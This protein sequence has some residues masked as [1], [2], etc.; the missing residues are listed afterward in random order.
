MLGTG[1]PQERC[2]LVARARQ[3]QMSWCD[4]AHSIKRP[5]FNQASWHRQIRPSNWPS[6]RAYIAVCGAPGAEERAM[7][8]SGNEGNSMS[9]RTSSELHV[10]EIDTDA[11]V[12]TKL[13]KQPAGAKWPVGRWGA[14]LTALPS[15]CVLWGGWSRAGDVDKAWKLWLREA[16]PEWCE[17]SM[18][19]VNV[20]PQVA[21]H[22]ASALPDG[23]MAVVGGLGDG[24]S[25]SGVWLFDALSDR[26]DQAGEGG[27]TCAGH[28]AGVDPHSQRL[29]LWGGVERNRNRVLPSDHFLDGLR[30]FDIRQQ[31]WVDTVSSPTW[32][33]E[34]VSSPPRPRRNAAFGNL[35]SHL[36]MT[37]GYSDELHATLEDTWILNLHS[38]RWNR[39][40]VSGAPNLEGHRAVISGLD[41][42]TFGGRDTT[43]VRAG[44]SMS[45]SRLRLGSGGAGETGLDLGQEQDEGSEESEEESIEEQSEEEQSEEEQSE[46]EVADENPDAAGQF[47][48]VR[49]RDNEGAVRVV[50]MPADLLHR[51]ILRQQVAEA[52]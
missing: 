31:R 49:V 7:L 39:L 30:I 6:H 23:R 35:G 5:T 37:G 10:A 47:M 27:G 44:R 19:M 4:I 45:I 3:H 25:H 24:G 41:F 12:C 14:S 34:F 2:G 9:W 17:V 33:E 46:N 40:L 15:C 36:I 26:W 51:L 48:T 42:F 32:D 16:T 21:F 18:P 28:C 29:V 8:F 20:P 22:T 52:E 13:L 50:R 11:T 1:Y 43:A 38:Y